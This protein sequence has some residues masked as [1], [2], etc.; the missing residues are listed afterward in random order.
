ML[1]DI[2]NAMVSNI[3]AEESLVEYV[4]I[5]LENIKIAG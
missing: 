4:T 3:G 5:T 1:Y 2:A